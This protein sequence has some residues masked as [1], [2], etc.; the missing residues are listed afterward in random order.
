MTPR[1][2]AE[3]ASRSFAARLKAIRKSNKLT[4][5]QLAE[6]AECSSVAL[7]KFESGVNLPSFENLVALAFA[8]NA[9]TDEL[10][11]VPTDG[12]HLTA[13]EIAARARL[14]QATIGLSAEWIDTLTELA[15]KAK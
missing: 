7:S 3:Q 4:Q 15:K 5:D 9:T 8:L 12:E 2:K 14:D 11:G 13:S 6:L 10:L 1:T